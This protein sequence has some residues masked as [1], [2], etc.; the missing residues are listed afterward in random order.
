MD[1]QENRDRR[2]YNAG[3]DMP[4]T[5]WDIRHKGHRRK[6]IEIV[7]QALVRKFGVPVPHMKIIAAVKALECVDCRELYVYDWTT[8]EIKL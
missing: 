8:E 2:E 1:N 4:L 5:M 7:D 6:C 3:R